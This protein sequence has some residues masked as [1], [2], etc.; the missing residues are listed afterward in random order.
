MLTFSVVDRSSFDNV[1][2]WL[3][4]ITENAGSHVTRVLVGNK[5]D[6]QYTRVVTGEEA[7][8]MAYDNKMRYFET[9]ALTQTNVK[10]VF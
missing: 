10:D 7:E 5:C 3:R 1:E 2:R 9:S 6:L 4:E 8:Q